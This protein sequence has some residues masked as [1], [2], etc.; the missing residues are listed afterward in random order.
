MVTK[1]MN[2]IAENML[3]A[4][5]L[6]EAAKDA[7]IANDLCSIEYVLNTGLAKIHDIYDEIE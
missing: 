3:N 6:L 1:N 2:K 5:F 7:C 4:I